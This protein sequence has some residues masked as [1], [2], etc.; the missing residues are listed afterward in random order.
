MIKRD[1]ERC[2]RWSLRGT[3]VCVKHGAQLKTVAD[4]AAAVVDSA[5][6]R[7][8][9]LSTDA[10]DVLEQLFQ[11]GTA[12]GIR[13]KAATEVLDRAGIRGGFELD[14]E[15]SANIDPRE[16]IAMRLKEIRERTGMVEQHDVIDGEVVPDGDYEQDTLFNLE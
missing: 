11:P 12:E 13:L 10:V 5:R 2:K 16:I 6:L 7:L 8:V 9:D 4:H 1:G 14:V 15:V 3:T